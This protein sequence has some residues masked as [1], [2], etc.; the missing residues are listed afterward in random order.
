MPIPESATVAGQFRDDL[1]ILAQEYFA[2]KAATRFIGHRAAP[3]FRV[4]QTAGEYPTFNRESFK[5]TATSKRAANGSYNRII[6]TFGRATWNT[7]E[8]GLEYPIDDKTAAKYVRFFDAEN[9]ATQV[10]TFQ[11]Q[12][13]HEERVSSLFSNGGWTNTNVS[14][15]W[16]TV[17]TATPI[18]DIQTGVDTLMDKT[19]VAENDISIIIPRADWKELNLVDQFTEKYSSTFSRNQGIQPGLVRAADAAEI[20]GVKEVLIA[21][22]AKDTKEENVTESNSQIWAAGVIYIC[23]LADGEGAPLEQSS[24]ARTIVWDAE[25]PGMPTME[26]YREE[27]LRRGIV[28]VREETD[29]I[30]QGETDLFVYQLTNT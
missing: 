19:G 10:L 26:A 4:A 14:T 17:A 6:G 20:F 22:S 7:E 27:N 2:E 24:A 3:I 25:T 1:S 15:A 18:S 29:E 8:Y 12:K 11:M 5:K 28:R 13:N 16:S 30:L 21:N 9:V 23:V